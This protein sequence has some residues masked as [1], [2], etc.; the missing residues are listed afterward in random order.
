MQ[1]IPAGARWETIDLHNVL[2]ADVRTIYQQRYLSPRP[3]T[4]SVRIGSDGY[5]PWTFP[6]WKIKTPSIQL[7]QVAKLLGGSGNL[8]TPQGVPFAWPGEAKNIAFTSL[9][10]NWPARVTV[11]V[12][13][14]GA[15]LWLLICGSTN[16]MQ[17]HIANAV[18]RLRYA[19]GQEDA[20]ELVPPQNY[21]NLCPIGAKPAAR[22]M[23]RTGLRL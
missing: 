22:Q 21:W 23:V 15:A 12:G 17:C 7:D 18:V 10:D 8:Q 13:K 16:P 5:S 3:D 20:L 14:K 1:Q 2:N 4:V 19:D 9:W 6:F 11:P